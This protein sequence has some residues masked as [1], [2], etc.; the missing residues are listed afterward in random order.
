MLIGV[1]CEAARSKM[2]PLRLEMSTKS[3]AI[4]NREFY[5]E[6]TDKKGRWVIWKVITAVAAAEKEAIQITF[7]KD[8]LLRVMGRGSPA[9]SPGSLLWRSPQQRSR[10]AAEARM[11]IRMGG[12]RRASSSRSLATSRPSKPSRRDTAR[13]KGA[14]RGQKGDRKGTERGQK[15]A[16]A[17]RLALL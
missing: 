8:T 14:E 6:R 9:Q 2:A 7:V 16:T 4:S 11:P 5:K 3:T 1:I 13:P 10:C 15:G 12:S 17:G